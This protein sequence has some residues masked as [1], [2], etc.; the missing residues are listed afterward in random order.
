MSANLKTKKTKKKPNKSLNLTRI[1]FKT[2]PR[3][4]F[5]DAVQRRLANLLEQLLQ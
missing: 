5:C 3:E 1:Q 2:V 4:D